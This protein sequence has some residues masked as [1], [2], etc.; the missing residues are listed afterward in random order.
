MSLVADP[1]ASL[2]GSGV[3][4]ET[5]T[6]LPERIDLWAEEAEA[7]RT[8]GT[9]RLREFAAG[10]LCARRAL[11]RLGVPEEP[12]LTGPGRAPCWPAGVC[13]SIAHTDTFCIAAVARRGA[14]RSL[15]V[16]AE[17]D[18]PLEAELWKSICTPHDLDRLTAAP[19]AVRGRLARVV[20]SAKECIYKVQYPLTGVFLEFHDADLAVDVASG[21]F[22]A[23][24]LRSAGPDFPAGLQI[25][26]RFRS[27][28]GM[29]VTAIELRRV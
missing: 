7:V 9:K 14:V 26:G 3:I 2:F 4:V 10:R 8:A 16:D 21:C 28:G 1:L 13:G 15:G 5:V 20:F 17:P 23:T 12:L 11:G 19:S 29:L 6:P 27:I 25:D 22:R 18:E 24:L